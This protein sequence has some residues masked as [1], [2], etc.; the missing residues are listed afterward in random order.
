MNC[1][2][3]LL[4]SGATIDDPREWAVIFMLPARLIRASKSQIKFPVGG[5]SF[6]AAKPEVA[7]AATI[8]ALAD[9]QGALNGVNGTVM[10]IFKCLNDNV[11]RGQFPSRCVSS[12]VVVVMQAVKRMSRGSR[13]CSAVGMETHARVK[14][15]PCGGRV[16][17]SSFQNGHGRQRTLEAAQSVLIKHLGCSCR[18]LHSW[19]TRFRGGRDDV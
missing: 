9:L 18:K 15:M 12:A 10:Y 3:P 2:T 8:K 14:R 6:G 1:T 13:A 7:I 16:C 5:A 17:P 4:G 11:P 19:R